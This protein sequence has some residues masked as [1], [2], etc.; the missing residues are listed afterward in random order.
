[1]LR[2]RN[3]IV[4][5]TT[6]SVNKTTT[7]TT[8]QTGLSVRAALQRAQKVTQTT[9]V[10]QAQTQAQTQ[11]PSPEMVDL[12]DT[13]E[14]DVFFEETIEINYNE[15]CSYAYTPLTIQHV[16]ADIVGDLTDGM[17]ELVKDNK[18]KRDELSIDFQ[19]FFEARNVQ[20]ST[21]V[22]FDLSDLPF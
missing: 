13:T 1:M 17:E 16:Y 5:T 7:S 4:E 2:N 8:L 6:P 22:D 21:P 9:Q 11:I 18:D 10:K 15:P 3:N 20:S 12:Y 19:Q 14:E